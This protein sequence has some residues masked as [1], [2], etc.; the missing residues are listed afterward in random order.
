[1]YKKKNNLL[2][3]LSGENQAM[4][5]EYVYWN[6][7][8]TDKCYN[9]EGYTPRCGPRPDEWT[10]GSGNG[11]ADHVCRP[12]IVDAMGRKRPIVCF[13]PM[14]N[15]ESYVTSVETVIERFQPPAGAE[16]KYSYPVGAEEYKHCSPGKVVDEQKYGYPVKVV[17]YKYSSP[18]RVVDEHKY[19]YPVRV[20]YRH[21]SPEKV[22]YIFFFNIYSFCIQRCNILFGR[23][24][25]LNDLFPIINIWLKDM[26]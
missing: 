5:H 7:D 22:C 19:S 14:S 23:I 1:M 6:R 16:Y 2:K 17:E 10:K 25:I 21:S 3:V 15:G 11:H 20:E 9:D 4:A 26:K 13:T 12:V 18:G 24:F 8:Q